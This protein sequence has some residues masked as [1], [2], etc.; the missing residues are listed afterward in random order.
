[1]SKGE[2]IL[3]EQAEEHVEEADAQK[4]TLAESKEPKPIKCIGGNLLFMMLMF[5]LLQVKTSVMTILRSSADSALLLSV[6]RTQDGRAPR[7]WFSVT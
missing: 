7:A 6:P 2:P 1:M 3:P 4:V 5:I